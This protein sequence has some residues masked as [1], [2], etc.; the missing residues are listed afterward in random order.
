MPK[1][2]CDKKQILGKVGEELISLLFPPRCPVCDEIL[3]VGQQVCSPCREFLLWAKEPVCMRCGRTLGREETEY[4]TDC[5]VKKH[6][7]SQG[8]AVF[9]YGGKIRRSLYRFKY[10]GRREYASFYATEAARL[11]ESWIKSKGVEAIVPVPM[12]RRKERLRGYNQAEV[13]AQALGK[14]L[15]LPV[16][17]LV[18]R[19]RDTVPQKELNER[20]R[21][22]NVKN[23]FQLQSDIVK[24]KRVLLVD[25][26]YTTGSTMDA[27]TEVLLDAG[28]MEVYF[29]CISIGEGV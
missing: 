24:Y 4:C 19:T 18:R 16:R 15:K 1:T 5:R 13:F 9:L 26:I 17:N 28:I 3:P 20:E 6:L 25:D 10:Y 29:I 12:Y 21:K 14:K 7:F 23:A 2:A 27:V 11:W 22:H 8:R